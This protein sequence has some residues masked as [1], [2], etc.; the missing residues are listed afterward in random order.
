MKP[1]VLNVFLRNVVIVEANRVAWPS[2]R[3]TVSLFEQMQ[4]MPD[5]QEDALDYPGVST[6]TVSNLCIIQLFH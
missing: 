2:M 4:V 6:F 1:Q 5:L 3:Y